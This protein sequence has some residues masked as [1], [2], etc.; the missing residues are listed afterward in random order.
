MLNILK[1]ILLLFLINILYTQEE[2]YQNI[3]KKIDKKMLTL[4]KQNII[5]IIDIEKEN[6]INIIDKNF[7]KN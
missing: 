3:S 6:I 1:I 2:R 5:N 7:R 4:K